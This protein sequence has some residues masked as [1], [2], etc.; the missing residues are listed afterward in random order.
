MEHEDILSEFEW[1]KIKIDMG[2]IIIMMKKLQE[3]SIFYLS[4]E[5]DSRFWQEPEI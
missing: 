1:K 2:D 3:F 4:V 5:C